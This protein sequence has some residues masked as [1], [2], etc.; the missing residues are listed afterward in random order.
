MFFFLVVPRIVA[1]FKNYRSIASCC[2]HQ[3]DYHKLCH[4]KSCFG[5]HYITIN[6]NILTQSLTK[7]QSIHHHCQTEANDWFTWYMFRWEGCSCVETHSDLFMFLEECKTTRTR[8]NHTLHQVPVSFF[9]FHFWSHQ[10]V[11]SH[12]LPVQQRAFHQST[13]QNAFPNLP[14]VKSS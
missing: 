14:R 3:K 11:V 5:P 1:R 7:T 12:E 13:L 2:G 8:T 10:P 4:S 6:L 9:L